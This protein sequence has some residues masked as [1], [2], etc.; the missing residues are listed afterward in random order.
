MNRKWYCGP[1]AT[2]NA[3]NQMGDAVFR[4][5]HDDLDYDSTI[6]H[7]VREILQNSLDAQ[8]LH[9]VNKPVVVEIELEQL[10]QGQF[11]EKKSLLKRLSEIESYYH[12]KKSAQQSNVLNL[13]AK[14]RKTTDQDHPVWICRFSDFGTTGLDCKEPD[15]DEGWSP[16]VQFAK[17]IGGSEK[18]PMLSG[19]NGFG[20]LA[21]FASTLSRTIIYSTHHFD[22]KS[23]GTIGMAMLAGILDHNKQGRDSNCY[24]GDYD[25]DDLL[26]PINELFPVFSHQ[27]RV[28]KPGL[29]VCLVDVNHDDFT[30]FIAPA[31]L[32]NFWLAIAMGKLEVKTASHQFTKET[33]ESIFAKEISKASRKSASLERSLSTHFKLYSSYI[34]NEELVVTNFKKPSGAALYLDKVS[35][36]GEKLPGALARDLNTGLY[37]FNERG[38]LIG[39]IKRLQLRT[40]TFLGLTQPT[41]SSGHILKWAE[42]PSHV[43][44]SSQYL[45][46]R[47]EEKGVEGNAA[48]LI[49]DYRAKIS[50]KIRETFASSSSEAFDIDLEDFY[51]P[52]DI[53]PKSDGQDIGEPDLTPIQE[54]TE[55]Q[56]LELKRQKELREGGRRKKKKKVTPPNP[57]PPKPYPQP[58]PGPNPSEDGQMMINARC[59]LSQSKESYWAK[60]LRGKVNGVSLILIDDGGKWK[61]TPITSAI[62][63]GIE[64][65]A[66][67]DTVE[68]NSEEIQEIEVFPAEIDP[69]AYPRAIKLQLRIKGDEQ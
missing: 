66:K 20:R 29:D 32:V 36:W 17:T 57:R 15:K 50:E 64:I 44:Y 4:D 26:Y 37:A 22:N 58:D 1:S 25:Q 46:K 12:K 68:L 24:L 6:E 41:G 60:N 48:T 38:M 40:Q 31:V 61:K 19:Q 49:K 52:F 13:T 16:F 7:T 10:T 30:H 21:P 9:V 23:V 45:R 62:I 55:E 27:T 59:F 2:I 53:D 5:R 54:L 14:V 69:T 51:E 28:Q 8:P 33:L 39:R 43:S 3:A 67:N 34:N 65:A 56:I 63:N 47:M 42:D 35:I 18:D 11:P